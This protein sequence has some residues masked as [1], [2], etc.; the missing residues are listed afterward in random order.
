MRETWIQ[1]LGCEDPPEKGKAAHSSILVWRIPWTLQSMS[2]QRVRHHWATVTFRM[3]HCFMLL[4]LFTHCCFSLPHPPPNSERMENL[5]SCFKV[6]VNEYLFWTAFPKSSQVELS[7]LSPVLPWPISHAV[8]THDGR[9]VAQGCSGCGLCKSRNFVCKI[10]TVMYHAITF[11]LFFH[12]LFLRITGM[13]KRDTKIK[14]DVCS[15][16]P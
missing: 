6:Q 5:Y 15:R 3:L 1:S 13:E 9:V 14:S 7:I 2:S 4:C 8:R 12:S 11:K 16:K 10:S